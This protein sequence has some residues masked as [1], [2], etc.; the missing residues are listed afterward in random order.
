MEERSIL[1]APC[2]R[3]AKHHFLAF[4]VQDVTFLTTFLVSPLERFRP[5]RK[6]SRSSKGNANAT[7]LKLF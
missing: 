1:G 6:I 4:S 7:Y 5:G 3:S 2:S